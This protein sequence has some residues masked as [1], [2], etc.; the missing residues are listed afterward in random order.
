MNIQERE[1][2]KGLP[3]VAVVG[4]PNVGKS[5]LF[6]RLIGKRQ[7]ITDPTPGVTR[8]PVEGVWDLGNHRI[9]LIDTG[10]FK[11]DQSG[12]DAQVTNRSLSVLTDAD[13]IVFLMDVT[14]TTPEDE[15]LAKILRKY[16][17]KILLV[18]NKV[19]SEKREPDVWNFYSYGFEHVVGIS[20]A[21][22][23][24]IS[25]FIDKLEELID[26]DLERGEEIAP[27]PDIRIA[28]LGKPN[29]GKSTLINRFLGK[30]VSIVSDIPGTTRDVI[31]GRFEYRNKIYRVM[32][33]AGIRKKKRIG[34]NVE[35]Y[36]V[37][38]A[39]KTIEQS[40]VVLLM[41]DAVEGLGDQDKKIATQIVKKGCG[42]VLVLNKWDRV[43]EVP[44]QMEAI[45]DRTKFLFPVLSFAPLVP[46][47]AATGEGIDELFSQI[48][49]VWKQLFH[50]VE[51]SALNSALKKWVE[52]TE[53]PRFKGG[54]YKILYGTQVSI[55]PVRFVLFVNRK[56]SFPE[57]YLQY[58]K[59]NI[60]TELGFSSIPIEVEL[61]ER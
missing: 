29:T 20:A 16:S 47:S 18:V 48:Y 34:E 14:E 38:R 12:L 3:V 54:R 30:E 7:A 50:R 22:G 5:T 42:V 24:G 60:R 51:T 21:H 15:A 61:K 35:Y 13:L 9:K 55:N 56:R 4:R 1:N 43:K 8:D 53:P 59:N 25:E 19:D 57:S 6:N 45:Q 37:N 33:T 26:F 17:G 41:I 36:S 23:I 44:N 49:K 27:E 11:V 32:D 58:I 39:I 31:E 52:R 2:K 10:G 46:L 28:L 40:D